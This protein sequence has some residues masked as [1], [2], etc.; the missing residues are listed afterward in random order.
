MRQSQRY[1]QTMAASLFLFFAKEKTSEASDWAWVI[2]ERLSLVLSMLWACNEGMRC[3]TKFDMY[4]SHDSWADKDQVIKRCQT[5]TLLQTPQRPSSVQLQHIVSFIWPWVLA[6]FRKM[7]ICRD[8]S[9]LH[10]V[11][12]PPYV[13][14]CCGHQCDW[15]A[16]ILWNCGKTINRQIR[17]SKSLV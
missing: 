14:N 8:M 4:L 3:E 11:E 16:L 13:V 15:T 1:V 6:M 7:I 5:T 12:Q 10:V 2:R 17:K 9:I